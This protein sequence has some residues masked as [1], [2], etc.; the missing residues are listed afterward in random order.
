MSSSACDVNGSRRRHFCRL[1]GKL[2]GMS[3]VTFAL[4][5]VPLSCYNAMGIC[6]IGD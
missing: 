4:L 3:Y 6:T 2:D 1:Q 5:H